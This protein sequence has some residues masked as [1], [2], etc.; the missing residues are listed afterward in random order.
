MNVNQVKFLLQDGQ[1]YRTR[2]LSF[3]ST[4]E[5]SL[6]SARK[7]INLPADS[8][9]VAKQARNSCQCLRIQNSFPGDN[10][11]RTSNGTELQCKRNL[12]GEMDKTEICQRQSSTKRPLSEHDS[13]IGD[14]K[15][16]ELYI[17]PNSNIVEFTDLTY[18]DKV[19]ISRNFH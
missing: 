17:F 7:S 15:V 4:N 19:Q 3:R 8:L 9:K 12:H 10:G 2:I 5:R 16:S 6:Y 18:D 14:E 13:P 11:F 1:S